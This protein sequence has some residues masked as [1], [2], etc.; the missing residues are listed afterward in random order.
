[1]NT[2]LG[3]KLVTNRQTGIPCHENKLVAGN[4]RSACN[5][6]I[7]ITW[8]ILAMEKER[9]PYDLTGMLSQNYQPR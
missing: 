4:V 3:G 1:M 2:L 6:F 7:Y 5:Q 8:D 9:Y